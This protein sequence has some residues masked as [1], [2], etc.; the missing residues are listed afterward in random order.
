MSNII[1][2]PSVDLLESMRSVGYSLPSALADIIDNSIDAKSSKVLLDLDVVDGHYIAV[3]DDG[4]GM[5]REQAIDALRLAGTANNHDK[6]KLG[7]FGLGLKTA[8][9]SQARKLTVVTKTSGETTALSWDIDHVQN[10]R[11]WSL[12]ELNF[13]ERD[14]L[15]LINQLSAQKSGTLVIW[16]NLDLLL[17]DSSKPGLF[18]AEKASDLTD[19]IALT[20]HRFLLRK[21]NRIRIELNG[22]AIKGIDPF[23]KDNVQ[24]QMTPKEQFEVS[25][26]IVTY[27]SYTLPHPSGLSLEEKQRYDLSDGMR[28]AQ[29]FYIF[30]NDRLISRGHWFGLARMNEISKQTRVEVDIP[31]ELDQLWQLNIMKSRTEPPASFKQALRRTIEPI[32]AKGKRLHTFRGRKVNDDGVSHVWNKIQL[33]D[34]FKYEINLEN[35]VVLATL[36]S[37]ETKQAE[38]LER[39]FSTI[40]AE[41]PH[42]DSYQELAT[43][44]QPIMDLQDDFQIEAKLNSIKSAAIFSEDPSEVF[45]Y[46]RATEPFTKV[47]N[48]QQLISKV[49]GQ[50][51]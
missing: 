15:P 49:W 13:A 5:N 7:R 43:N 46:L 30:R 32:L 33:H 36:N 34:G 9:L 41:F 47:D 35:P 6:N 25:G 3:L 14:R 22:V 10:S 39:L 27:R 28:D 44:A 2:E 17:G 24:T 12:L 45:R 11:S 50:N 1:V 51:G 8:S 18:L 21:T 20:F 48:L 38:D 16:E 4:T 19:H 31:R 23:L 26:A 42:F 37:L 40:A 29:G